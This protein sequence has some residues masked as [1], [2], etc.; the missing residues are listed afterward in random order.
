[1]SGAWTARPGAFE[2]VVPGHVFIE[3]IHPTCIFLEMP[4]E[5]GFMPSTRNCSV[6]IGE[7]VLGAA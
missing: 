7:T 6:P 3:S 2:C 1:M 4:L 5:D